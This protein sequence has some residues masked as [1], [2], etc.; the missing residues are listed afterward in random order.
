MIAIIQNN[1]HR[2]FMIK[3]SPQVKYNACSV[4]KEEG[5]ADCDGKPSMALLIW[6][7]KGFWNWNLDFMKQPF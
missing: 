6:D 7:F 4:F 3:K 1:S 2:M 5:W